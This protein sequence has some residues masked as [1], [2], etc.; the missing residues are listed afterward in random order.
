M[1]ENI[2]I[3]VGASDKGY[4]STIERI[5]R[6]NKELEE[7]MIRTKGAIESTN[8]AFEQSKT[9]MGTYASDIK[10]I[11]QNISGI[12]I[13][14]GNNT[15]TNVTR[16]NSYRNN[17]PDNLTKLMN[18][19]GSTVGLQ[20]KGVK[21]LLDIITNVDKLFKQSGVSKLS[22]VSNSAIRST[23]TNV[24]SSEALGVTAESV[25]IAGAATVGAIGAVIAAL[26]LMTAAGYAASQTNLKVAQSLQQVGQVGDQIAIKEANSLIELKNKWA[27]AGQRI[28]QFFEPVYKGMLSLGI[29]LAEILNP[30][31]TSTGAGGLAPGN[32]TL[33]NYANSLYKNTGLP[34]SQ[35]LTSMSNIA[36]QA[37]QSGLTNDS[38][39]NL[40]VG[41]FKTAMDLQKEYGD[42]AVDISKSISDA[43]LTGSDAASKYGINMNDNTLKGWLMQE[44]G[45]DAVNVKISDAQLKYYR[46][47]FMQEQASAH[48]SDAMQK[49]IKQWTM[50]GDVINSAKNQLFSFDKVITL[51]AIDPT[52]PDV[53]NG[54]SPLSVLMSPEAEKFRDM[55][56]DFDRT[57]KTKVFADTSEG[58]QQLN[59]FYGEFKKPIVLR[60]DSTE[61]R[62]SLAMA[63]QFKNTAA[64][65][66]VK[67]KTNADWSGEYYKGGFN[68]LQPLNNTAGKSLEMMTNTE[69]LS[70][71]SNMWNPTANDLSVQSQ[72][73]SRAN[74]ALKSLIMHPIDTI[75][76]LFNGGSSEPTPEQ[77]HNFS[78][79]MLGHADGGI[80]LKDHPAMVHKNEVIAPL[81]GKNA[82]PFYE[83]LSSNLVSR[84]GGASN[85][86]V[87]LTVNFGQGGMI[88]ADQ[89]AMDKVARWL[90]SRMSII[91]RGTGN[92]NYGT[93]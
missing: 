45:I 41:T 82:E 72:I 31:S 6:R 74:E 48:N 80:T 58:R 78:N 76:N 56:K 4:D 55:L 10:D 7:Q 53:G 43:W 5:I 73:K 14:T 13:N 62:Q 33:A 16:Q 37:K 36:G 52:I 19:I 21:S 29:G 44:K 84:M 28:S 25:G 61:L 24:A 89:S 88:F 38:V 87:S 57:I 49:N 32:S 66:E 50:L 18:S 26:G 51:N 3:N 83:Q 63:E 91:Q 22:S 67:N 9:S 71:M 54:N 42:N 2:D 27:D 92:Y 65:L 69:I 86:D 93:K 68:T 40:A 1:A 70:G 8:R 46:Y 39:S 20:N 90:A 81:D 77:L 30:A 85:G 35:S 12:N 64:R 60:V 79:I 34:V 11:K 59:S 23:A 47:Q 75:G 17:T 15:R